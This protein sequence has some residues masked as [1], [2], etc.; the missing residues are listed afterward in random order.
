[1]KQNIPLTTYLVLL[2][3]LNFS[4]FFSPVFG[5]N[6]SLSGT[7]TIMF[8]TIPNGPEKSLTPFYKA[9]KEATPGE[10]RFSIF[11]QLAEHHIE[12]S[13][14]DSIIRYGNLYLEEVADW[15]K[16]ENK[17]HLYYANAYY[18]LGVGNKLHGLLDNAVKWHIKGITHATEG[19]A[20][21]Y[22]FRNKIGL[23][24][25]YI[26]KAEYKKALQ[27]A[28]EAWQTYKKELPRIANEAL[29]TM[30][31]AEFYLEENDKA[32]TYYDL[33]LTGSKKFNDVKQELT[34]LLQ[35]GKI[36]A[37]EKKYEEAYTLF[38]DAKER[39]KQNGLN[40]IYFDGTIL[41][42]NLLYEQKSYQAAMTGLTVAYFNAI[43]RDNLHY[44]NKILS[45][46]AKVF[47]AQKDYQN[48]Y[49]VMTQ[50]NRVN[51]EINSQ[52]QRKIAKE[53]EVQ[54]ETLQ[55]ENEILSLKENQLKKEAE[56]KNQK[57]I[58]YAILIGFM[59]LL[60]PIVILLYVYY[61]K[62]QTQSELAKKQKEIND[63]K[64]KSLI[65]EQELNVIKAAIEGQDEERK[66]IAQELH[67]SIGGNL[68]G[69]KLQLASI[70]KNDSAFSTISTQLDDTYQLVRDISHTLVPK[71][72]RQ[73][74]FVELVKEYV[75]SI[76]ATGQLEVGFHP[77]PEQKVNAIPDHIQAELFK[78]IQELMTNTI[79]HAKATKVDIHLNSYDES[80]SLLF[81]DN[82][83][84]FNADIGSEGIGFKNIRNRVTDLQGTLHI[85]ASPNRGTVISVDI[86]NTTNND[87]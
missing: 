75:K 21:A 52:Q 86:L 6:D 40:T 38:E 57:T 10:Q 67:D 70:S 41:I 51:N 53:L 81:E 48:A 42:G 16:E 47:S 33:A 55:K 45:T 56:L 72:F 7:R 8:S 26:L 35:L 1:M 82:G 32:K 17:K 31:D 76:T 79:K 54:Y 34:T 73:N 22:L 49:A 5:Q 71:K 84:G 69:I 46:Q 4:S 63:Q 27:T 65:Q 25:T 43:D 83:V 80:I 61:Q 85:D 64:V 2:L 24:Q 78:I 68:A 58:K 28:K 50:L 9:L 20:T 18:L 77:Y 30:G 23:A 36:A 13:N 60:I 14:A 44:Q 37:L 39:A 11:N 15:H 3:F 59:V 62:I 12:K 29:V 19:N 66:R 74:A 87:V